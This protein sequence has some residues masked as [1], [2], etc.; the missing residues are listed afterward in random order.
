ML[1]EAEA[2]DAETDVIQDP[3]ATPAGWRGG[4]GG[5]GRRRK[6]SQERNKLGEAPNLIK[7]SNR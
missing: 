6:K 5:G 4:G 3:A 1:T 7:N 2:E